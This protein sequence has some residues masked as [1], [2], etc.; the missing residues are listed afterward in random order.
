MTLLSTC[1]KFFL[2]LT[3]SFSTKPRLRV[4]HK[5]FLLW[6]P[7]SILPCPS[8]IAQ[9]PKTTLAFVSLIMPRTHWLLPCFSFPRLRGSFFMDRTQKKCISGKPAWLPHLGRAGK[10]LE[11]VRLKSSLFFCLPISLFLYLFQIIH[12]IY[13]DWF[14]CVSLSFLKQVRSWT[15]CI[16][17]GCIWLQVTKPK[18]NWFFSMKNFQS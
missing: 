5:L 8:W 17:W 6:A 9:F 16:Y 15:H 13:F 10:V 4:R 3:V 7:T 14:V 1:M 12:H 2:H 11:S 18:W